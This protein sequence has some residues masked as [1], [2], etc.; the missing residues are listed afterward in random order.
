MELI[1]I[2]IE[3]YDLI[4]PSMKRNKIVSFIDMWMDLD[5]VIQSELIQEDK[6]LY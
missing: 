2:I 5:T 6:K 1:D 3:Y 4:L